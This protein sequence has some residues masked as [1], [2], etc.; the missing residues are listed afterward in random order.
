MP[1]LFKL[2]KVI[3]PV[4]FKLATPER[5]PFAIK[6]EPDAVKAVDPAELRTTLPVED[7]P[8]VSVCAL[9]VPRTPLPCR[10]VALF[11]VFAE[12][13]AVGVPELTLINPIFALLVALEPSNRSWLGILSKILPLP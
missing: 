10:Y 4:A 7:P 8:K 6:L 5:L 1:I 9:V 2:E 11:A 3:V 13:V 12:I